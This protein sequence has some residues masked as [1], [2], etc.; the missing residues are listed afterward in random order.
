MDI[1]VRLAQDPAITA[2]HLC[3]SST[4]IVDVRDPGIQ[5]YREK[6]GGQGNDDRN[7]GEGRVGV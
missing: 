3:T 6:H 1:N 4:L 5:R 7:H 2:L